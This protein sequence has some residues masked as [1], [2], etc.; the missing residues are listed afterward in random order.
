MS[1]PTLPTLPSSGESPWYAK[2]SAWDEAVRQRLEGDLAP[3]AIAK[4]YERVFT[5]K[6]YG[7]VQ[8]G[9]TDDTAA[10]QAAV[11]AAVAVR[12][13]VLLEGRTAVTQISVTGPVAIRGRGA[14]GMFGKVSDGLFNFTPLVS[15][16]LTGTVLIGLGGTS[17]V[18]SITAESATVNLSDFGIT[19]AAPFAANTGHAI[20]ARPGA[21]KNGMT[22]AEWRNI[23]VFGHNGN[24]YALDLQNIAQCDF[25]GIKAWGGG[26]FQF[27]QNQGSQYGNSSFFGCMV[28]LLAGGS[29]HGGAIRSVSGDI[30]RITFFGCEFNAVNGTSYAALSG[31]GGLTAPTSAQYIF[32]SDDQK[33]RGLSMLGCAFDRGNAAVSAPVIPQAYSGGG[34]FLDPGGWY[35]PQFAMADAMIKSPKT[36]GTSYGILPMGI[37][38]AYTSTSAVTLTATSASTIRLCNAAGGAFAVTL[39]AVASSRGRVFT[40]KKIDSSANA[41]TV[42]AQ[43]GQTIDGSNTYVLATQYKHVRVLCDGT[44]WHVVAAG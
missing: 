34:V 26:L 2:R 39:P 3:S 4:A 6:A 29:A 43:A 35:D 38:Q 28:K 22:G 33:L 24:S 18:I 14:Y 9:V 13:T 41:V 7:A 37:E 17:S 8:D 16:F 31:F 40:I 19:W 11:D 5:P 10:V 21:N 12:G 27:E 44:A 20:S 42:T 15:P 32:Y 30:T 23:L 25:Y 36:N 1:D